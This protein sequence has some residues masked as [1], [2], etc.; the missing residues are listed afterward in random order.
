MKE[1]VSDLKNLSEETIFSENR[2]SCGNEVDL[3]GQ[4][5][6]ASK[7]D[8]LREMIECF[9]PCKFEPEKNAACLSSD[10]ETLLDDI[11]ELPDKVRVRNFEWCKCL[12]CS[13]EE[14]KIECLRC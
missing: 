8:E 11:S 12:K 3:E 4:E 10:E 1:E 7:I 6:C 13:I 2:G 9:Q 5:T 14:R